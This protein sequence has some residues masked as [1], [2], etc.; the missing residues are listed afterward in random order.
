[1]VRWMRL[2]RSVAAA[3]LAGWAVASAWG[4]A[5]VAWA[6]GVESVPAAAVTSSAGA[7]FVVRLGGAAAEAAAKAGGAEGG[8]VSGR[9][10]VLVIGPGAKLRP[11]TS[12]LDGPFWEDPQPLFSVAVNGAAVGE[13]VVVAGDALGTPFGPSDLPPGD[14][15]AAARLV[16]ARETS[17]WRETAG[18]LFTSAPVAFSVKPAATEDAAMPPTV[19][20]LTLDKVT[21]P[22]AFVPAAGVEVV[23]MRSQ[24]LSAFAGRPV[25]LRAGVVLPA[26]YEPAGERRYPAIYEVPGFGGR[27]TGANAVAA[28]RA[29]QAA[30]GKGADGPE[31]NPAAELARGS[32]WI[33][34]D[35]ESPNGHTLFADSANNGPWGRALTE[36][37]IPELE[38]R[39]RL[40]ARPEARLLRG[41]SSGG[42]STIWLAVT[43]PQVF[44]GA[45]STAPD[46]VDF[47]RFQLMDI[48]S[49]DNAFRPREDD[50]AVKGIGEW[51]RAHGMPSYRRGGAALMSVREEVGGEHVCG[52]DNTGG[53]QWASWQAVFGPR[54]AAGNPAA[55]LDPQTGSIDR[56]VAESYRRFDLGG[57]VRSGAIAPEAFDRVRLVVG[58][59]DNFYLEQA[60]MLLKA[61]LED[62]RGGRPGG[63][64]Y[65]RV[66]P[67]RDHGSVMAAPEV[68]GFAQEMV[69]HLRAA[70]LPPAR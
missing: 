24:L 56:T 64:G 35:P 16:R 21:T 61:S 17:D 43:Y 46:P 23:E 49:H 11:G 13:A 59:A 63:P 6:Q 57:L 7:Q 39:Y 51:V 44:G 45:W 19:V 37:L 66:V 31:G 58:D 22:E 62:K 26:G 14:Y 41:H 32:F 50:P 15:R 65:I 34:L 30:G 10:V 5:G 60:V 29:R 27:H 28:R 12:P 67:G 38:R 52:P 25:M 48:Y 1:V 40:I 33:V 42:W 70:V 69:D 47:R 54:N 18:N 36:E 2:V 55:L 53:G 8:K 20:E 3:G 9:L 68:R 4:S